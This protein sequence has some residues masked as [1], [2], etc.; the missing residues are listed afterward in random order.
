MNTP[1]RPARPMLFG[2][3]FAG[4]AILLSSAIAYADDDYFTLHNKTSHKM[5][6]LYVGTTT[7][8]SWGPNILRGSAAA[9]SDIKVT[10]SKSAPDVCK[11]DVRGEFD[12]GTSAE[13]RDVDFCSV[14]E[15]TFH[16]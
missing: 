15:V 11:W 13:V 12:D 6:A 5:V 14:D 10:W 4:L 3:L 16:D 1:N 2:A 8:D 7:D 9:G